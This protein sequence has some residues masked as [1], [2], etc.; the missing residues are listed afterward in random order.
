LA[1][2]V[3]EF[4]KVLGPLTDPVAQG[5]SAEDAFHAIIPSLPNFGFRDRPR[6]WNPGRTAQAWF[7][8]LRKREMGE[9]MSK[10]LEDSKCFWTEY[11]RGKMNVIMHLVSFL[12][13]FYGLSIKSVAFVLTGLFVFDEMGHAYNYFFVHNRA[14]IWSPDDPVPASVRVVVYGCGAQAL[15]MV[16]R[17]LPRAII[18]A[19]RGIDYQARLSAHNLDEPLSELAS[20][21]EHWITADAPQ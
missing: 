16:L 2:S 5:G 18:A 6:G 14:E 10:F 1:G 3:L 13:L 20:Q 4:E 21:T 19:L 11:H 12:F 15:S 17:R 7:W 8:K 9:N